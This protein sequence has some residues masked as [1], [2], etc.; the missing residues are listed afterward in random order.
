M[1]IGTTNNHAPSSHSV[2]DPGPACAAAGIQRVPTM[3][4]MANSVMSRR[5]SSRLSCNGHLLPQLHA[6]AAQPFRKEVRLTAQP[7]TDE[8]F[9]SEVDA[10]HDEHALVHAD[11]LA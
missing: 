6:D 8:S 4:A 11:A 1:A 5:P 2:T 7:H 3:Q 10:R 9:E